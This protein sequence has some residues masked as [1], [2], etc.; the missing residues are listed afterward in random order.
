MTT[1]SYNV[2]LSKR[3]LYFLS[4]KYPINGGKKLSV[5]LFFRI[6][7]LLQPLQLFS[8]AVDKTIIK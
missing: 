7:S 2:R 1:H 4:I 5:S 3:L 8:L 6:I